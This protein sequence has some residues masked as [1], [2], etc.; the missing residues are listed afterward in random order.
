MS[1]S[2]ILLLLLTVAVVWAAMTYNR[3]IRLR[4]QVSEAW[5]DIDVQLT[6]RFDLIPNL[7]ELVKGYQRHESDVLKD[8]TRLRSNAQTPV[9][10]RATRENELTGHI[11]NLFAIAEDYPDLKADESFRSLHESLAEVEDHLQFSRRFYN[12][13][14]RDSNNLVEGFP[15]MIIAT[16]FSFKLAEFFEIELASMR[17]APE[18]DL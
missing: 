8:V 14:V 1:V 13:T 11:V 17:E 6:R 5:A 2:V 7:V 9:D 10:R 15:S 12:G 3:L 18:V 4:N 16:A